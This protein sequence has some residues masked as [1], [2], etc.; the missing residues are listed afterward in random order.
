MQ[1]RKTNLVSEWKLLITALSTSVLL[2]LWA[3]F[4]RNSDVPQVS[5]NPLPTLVPANELSNFSS[6]GEG[7]RNQPTLSPTPTVQPVIIR[8]QNSGQPITSSSSSR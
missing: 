3:L 2:G 6:N 7:I 5:Q 4:S 8:P 1:N